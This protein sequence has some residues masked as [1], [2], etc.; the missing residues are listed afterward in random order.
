MTHPL[1]QPRAGHP[2]SG[3]STTTQTT[4][5]LPELV[6]A[7]RFAA[8]RDVNWH[9]HDGAELVL[10]TRGRCRIHAGLWLNGKAGTLFVLPARVKQYAES[11]GVT[12]TSYVVFRAP[13]ALISSQPRTLETSKGDA[14]RIW[15][16]QLCDLHES[17][18]SA[19]DQSTGAGLLLACLSRVLHLE[20]SRSRAAEFHPA[21]ARAMAIVEAHAAEPMEVG[22]LAKAANISACH[23]TALFREQLGV[24]PQRYVRRVRMRRAARLLLN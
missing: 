19:M 16:E 2:D 7:G 15:I 17:G 8:S 12:H 14:I 11:H 21:V 10:V 5:F 23:L 6:H 3:E 1:Q 18:P 9:A 13:P 20:A 24:A 4:T 22:T